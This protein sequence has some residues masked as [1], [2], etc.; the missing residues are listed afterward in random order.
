MLLEAAGVDRMLCDPALDSLARG[1]LSAL[2]NGAVR[3][4]VAAAYCEA[5]QIR[6]PALRADPG[7]LS[8]RSSGQPARI[9]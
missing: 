7:V 1:R 3:S 9:R 5:A 4:F 6:G 8:P 2:E